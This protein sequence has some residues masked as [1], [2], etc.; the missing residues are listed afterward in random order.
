ML[1]LLFCR[2][3][4][5][6]SQ[7]TPLAEFPIATQNKTTPLAKMQKTTPPV[8]S[9]TDTNELP[10]YPPY[11]HNST[12]SETRL[13]LSRHIISLLVQQLE[14]RKH[15]LFIVKS[16]C[17]RV[18]CRSLTFTSLTWKE[19]ANSTV[20][21]CPVTNLIRN[22]RVLNQENQYLAREATVLLV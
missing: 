2:S 9:L 21:L 16:T 18:F 1:R 17:R 7:H 20:I 3:R 5:L 15:C 10:P 22:H 11:W 19:F 4:I 6:T 12:F 13:L 14:A 8:K